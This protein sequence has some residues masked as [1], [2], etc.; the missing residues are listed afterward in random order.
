MKIILFL[1]FVLNLGLG[2]FWVICF[3]AG[4]PVSALLLG[5]VHIGMAFYVRSAVRD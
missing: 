4:A 3:I 5:L 1:M 2:L